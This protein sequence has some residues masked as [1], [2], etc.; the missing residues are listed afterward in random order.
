MDNEIDHQDICGSVNKRDINSPHVSP[1]ESSGR[2]VEQLH[3]LNDNNCVLSEA[4]AVCL[5]ASTGAKSI[6][7]NT[8]LTMED[9][10]DV[11]HSSCFE[12]SSV[13][14]PPVDPLHE[15]ETNDLGLIQC[16]GVLEIIFIQ[17]FADTFYES[18]F[19]FCLLIKNNKENKNIM[20]L[21]E[22]ELAMFAFHNCIT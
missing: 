16:V 17:T 9:I 19:P 13:Q 15:V 5:D 14:F 12:D 4:A 7:E 21:L 2:L 1:K 11:V 18:F 22:I 6:D 3:K 10:L 20:S 8:N